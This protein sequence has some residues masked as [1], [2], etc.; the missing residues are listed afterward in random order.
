MIALVQFIE[1]C[2]FQSAISILT[3][4]KAGGGNNA[5]RAAATDRRQR[6]HDLEEYELRQREKARGLWHAS[7]LP[8][9]TPVD[10]Y[11]ARI[12]I[13]SPANIPMVI[14]P[15]NNLFGLAICEG[16][17]D[18]LSAHR[19]TGLGAWASGSAS[20]MP[21]LASAVPDYVET[22]TIYAH[23]DESGKR[24]ARELAD[25]L[26]ARGFEIRIEGITP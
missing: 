21:K 4:E 9:A 6:E 11:A 19:A 18:A 8:M 24:S 1:W 25:A 14:A 22:V 3:G 2:S 23:A 26:A 10:A 16:V 5:P 7:E 20:F 17:E 15:V 12:T 13:A